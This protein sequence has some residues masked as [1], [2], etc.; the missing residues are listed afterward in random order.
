MQGFDIPEKY[1]AIK[2]YFDTLSSKPGWKQT[3]PV[4]GDSVIE[5]GWKAKESERIKGLYTVFGRQVR[6]CPGIKTHFGGGKEKYTPTKRPHAQ[7][8]G[9]LT[10]HLARVPS[11]LM[12]T[13]RVVNHA[14]GLQ[15]GYRK[16]EGLQSK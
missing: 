14:P 10:S 16:E 5:A 13:W 8:K 2:T 3:L 1:K 12:W 4:D 6:S 15:E 11:S 9:S 7:R